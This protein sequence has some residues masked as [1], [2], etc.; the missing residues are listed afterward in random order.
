MIT[1]V[2]GTNRPGSNTNKIAKAYFQILKDLQV[3]C[4]FLSLETNTV[5]TKNADFGR[6]ENEFLI[7]ADKFIFVFPEYN[8]SFPGILKL[9]IDNSDVSKCFHNKK[10]LLTGVAAG[11]AGNLRGMEH[12]TGS[13]MHMKMNVHPNRLPISLVHNLSYVDDVLSDENTLEAIKSQIQEFLTF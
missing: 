8:G 7:P 5:H 9:M 10:A 1:I 13:L 3:D 11:R 12:L 4:K 2:S 6:V